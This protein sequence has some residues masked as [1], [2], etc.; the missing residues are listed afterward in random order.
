[1][2]LRIWTLA[3]AVGAVG[4]VVAC[5]GGANDSN[6]ANTNGNAA[7]GGGTNDG[8]T[9]GTTSSGSPEGDSGTAGTLSC[10]GV[11]K[12]AGACPD[13]NSDACVEDCL[14]QTRK[15][16]QPVTLAFAK[17]IGDNQCA[18]A[19][20]IQ[21]KCESELTACVADDASEAEGTPT[22][23]PTPSGSVPAELVGI[24]SSGGTE[25]QFE[26]DGSTT[27]VFIS[28]SSY[29]C[30][31]KLDMTSSGVTT[32][33]GDS[34]VYHRVQGTMGTKSCTTVKSE[35]L[36]PADIAYR[37]AL[38]TYD[39]GAPKL[40]L[41]RVNEDGTTATSPLELHH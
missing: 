31:Y 25:Y 16:S 26:A 9:S 40:S 7:D 18:D 4:L 12:C 14:N 8:G 2:E 23:G 6:G 21:G 37:Y 10:L 35:A 13:E 39:D 19:P 41:F 29:Y 20:C 34:L 33:T 30:D 15:S 32:V 24:W 28:E 5:T 17:C 38:G 11:L 36:G 22:T 1:M 27:Q 3:A